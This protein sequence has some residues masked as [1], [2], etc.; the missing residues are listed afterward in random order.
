MAYIFDLDQTIVDSSIA[1]AYRRGRDWGKVYS[2]ISR[3]KLYDGINDVLALIRE[4]GEKICIVTS[5]PE[6]Y[7]KAVLRYFN[8]QVDCI[9]CYH[10]TKLHKPNSEP[11]VKAIE[12]LGEIPDNIISIGDDEK[13][14][15]ASKAA[16]VCGCLALWGTRNFNGYTSADY[17]FA[18]V[19]ELKKFITVEE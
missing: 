14:I 13:D 12:L 5:S 1:E 10:D 18:S 7:C 8:I 4:R 11:I 6:S 15:I 3:F 16:G 17:I 2:L 9:V 19:E